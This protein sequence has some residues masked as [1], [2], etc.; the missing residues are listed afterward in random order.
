MNPIPAIA[1]NGYAAT[2]ASSTPAPGWTPPDGT[3]NRLALDNLLRRELKVSD[4]SD[5]KMV[6]EALLRRYQGTPRAQAI[7]NEERGLPL[8]VTAPLPV[9]PVPEPGW[10]GGELQQALSDVDID[11]KELTSDSLLKDVA[12]ELQGWSQA[13]R[14]AIGE[15]SGAARFG[16]DPRQ[17]DKAISIRRQLGDYA[18]MARIVG[19]LTPSRSNEYRKLAQSLDEVAAVIL[20][21]LGEALANIGFQGG[22]FLLQV[23]FTELQVRRD[24]AIHALRNLVGA[25]QDAFAPGEWP[26]GL[27]AYRLLYRRLE[28]GGQGDL[29]ALLVETELARIMDE[30]IQ[31]VQNGNAEGMRAVGATARLDLHRF[32]RLVIIGS[33]AVTPESPPLNAFLQALELFVDAFLGTGG[34]RLLRVARPPILFYG[35]YSS[36]QPNAAEDRLLRLITARGQLAVQLDC[37]MACG[38]SDDAI[39]RQIVLDMILYQLDRAIDLYTV[40]STNFG[41]P[42]RRA[43][44]YGLV[45]EHLVDNKAV[46]LP[47]TQPA[48]VAQRDRIAK[49]LVDAGLASVPSPATNPKGP[50]VLT[51]SLSFGEVK[52]LY[53]SL[54]KEATDIGKTLSVGDKTQLDTDCGPIRN[55]LS[56]M[57]SPADGSTR[58]MLLAYGAIERFRFRAQPGTTVVPADLDNR[59]FA[60]TAH[61]ELCIQQKIEERWPDLIDA[62][63]PACRNNSAVFSHAGKLLAAVIAKLGGK[64][65]DISLTVPPHFETSWD[66]FVRGRAADGTGVPVTF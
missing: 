50:T 54:D 51:P 59:R 39:L 45:I 35:L 16:L 11:L 66:A 20:V 22:Q 4:P 3:A 65:D 57:P 40:G 64:C 24:A 38:C 18:R 2:A 60:N 9:Q 25:T 15:A 12:P 63:T 17:R 28:E 46:F 14:S 37:H 34:Q 19:A 55:A 27:N 53:Q 29:R 42:E 44:A 62:L 32:Q 31:R 41:E 52:P 10:T 30:L 33:T 7:R 5:A 8:P 61:D 58:D 21:M 26:R 6:A 36:N 56:V 49:L 43:A 13:I 23:P 48:E 47:A 1:P